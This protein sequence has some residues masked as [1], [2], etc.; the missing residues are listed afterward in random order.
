MKDLTIMYDFDYNK[1]SEEQA[2]ALCDFEKGYL[3]NIYKYGFD[4]AYYKQDN[5]LII[6]V[7]E[8]RA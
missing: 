5:V 3:E 2:I 7:D 8:Y 6:W 1:I 4:Y